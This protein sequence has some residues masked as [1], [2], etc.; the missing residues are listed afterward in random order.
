MGRK[1]KEKSS[2]SIKANKTLFE[3]LNEI[4]YIKSP[5]SSFSHGDINSFN[6]Y[7]INRFL[8][9]DLNNIELINYIQQFNL[10]SKNLYITLTNIIPKKKKFYKY[11]KSS[12]VDKYDNNILNFISNHYEISTREVKD[13]INILNEDELSSLLNNIGYNEEKI[14][15]VSKKSKKYKNTK[16]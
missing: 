7:M 4:S 13:Y 11:I 3:W 15:R 10:S 6:R 2:N 12:N 8:S 9:M 14:T 1:K 5:W 16:T